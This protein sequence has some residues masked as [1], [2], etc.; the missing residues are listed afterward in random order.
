MQN[1]IAQEMAF[2]GVPLLLAQQVHSNTPPP[3]FGTEGVS[4]RFNSYPTTDPHAFAAY[5]DLLSAYQEIEKATFAVD[6]R[7]LLLRLNK[8]DNYLDR[9][10]EHIQQSTLSQ[11]SVQIQ[12]LE[13]ELERLKEQ[14][15]ALPFNSIALFQTQELRDYATL[16]Y[17]VLPSLERE[18]ASL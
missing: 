7:E 9:A 4:S 3:S 11:F 5:V 8:A 6:K 15:Q 18:L 1:T 12:S 10:D 17:P 2:Q 14:A 16:L 13:E